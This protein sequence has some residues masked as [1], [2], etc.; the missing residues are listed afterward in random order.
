M[1]K[2]IALVLTLA[3]CLSLWIP[4]GAEEPETPALP[5]DQEI[6]DYA[7]YFM[8]D[9]QEDPSIAIRDFAHLTDGAGNPTGYYVSFN[10]QEGS[11]GYVLLS[12]ISGENPLVEF[13]FEGGGLF[14][15]EETASLFAETQLATLDNTESSQTEI[16]YQGAGLLYLPVEG[17]TYY[18]VYDRETTELETGIVPLVDLKGGVYDWADAHIKNSSVFKIRDFGDGE[19]DYRTMSHWTKENCDFDNTSSNCAPTAATNI[20]WYWGK[21]RSKST[22]MDM[23]NPSLSD[24]KQRAAIYNSLYRSMR[25]DPYGSDIDDVVIAYNNFFRN[26]SKN[27]WS[28]TKLNGV[29]LFTYKNA[30]NDQCPVHLNIYAHANKLNGGHATMA[31]GY[32]QSSISSS[33][34]Y[35]F[36]MDG[37]ESYGRFI[38]IGYYPAMDGL[39]IKVV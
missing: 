22:V 23:I 4:A 30:L 1:K 11:A 36:V 35:L 31:I 27:L 32:A 13:A 9:S 16:V 2:M 12:L 38:K 37:S 10:N 25:T 28:C 21:M 39:K 33:T 19:A 29:D 20:L 7:L 18:S 17:D 34:Y 14:D 3:L 26:A 24:D 15:T 6:M 5:T 8:T